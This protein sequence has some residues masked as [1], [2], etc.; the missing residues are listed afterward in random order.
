MAAS[1]S[2]TWAVV[3]AATTT[4]STSASRIIAER[5]GEAGGTGLRRRRLERRRVRVRDRGQDR[6]G[7]AG[8]HPQVVPPH[9]PEAGQ[10][11]PEPG[12]VAHRVTGVATSRIAATMAAR[13]S[14]DSFGCTGIAS[15]S[16][17]SRFVTG[18]SR[19]AAPGT[20]AWR[21][22]CLWIGTG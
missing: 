22:A 14:P 11:D 20:Y 21:Y 6:L 12:T 3:G 8:D 16:S 17:D 2:G 13:S 9:R 15:T 1:A 5:I 7:M 19:S 4:A 10:P 18:R